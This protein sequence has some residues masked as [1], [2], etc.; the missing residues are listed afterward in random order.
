MWSLPSIRPK[1]SSSTWRSRSESA[2]QGLLDLLAQHLAGGGV[3]RLEGIVVLDEIA[4]LAGIL[5]P[6]R[7]LERNRFLGRAQDALH[8]LVADCQAALDV[9]DRAACSSG[10][11][12]QD[13]L[14]VRARQVADLQ[15]QFLVGRLAPQLLGQV[16]L[17][18]QDARD[19]LRTRCT[20]MRIVRA[21]SAIER[22]MDWRIHQVA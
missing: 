10:L 15:G 3:H 1:R 18:A 2:V 5:V 8:L 16:T 12:P 4:Q 21:C 6:H 13:G 19:R 7:T 9:P 20:G 17:D 22:L 11:G 14:H